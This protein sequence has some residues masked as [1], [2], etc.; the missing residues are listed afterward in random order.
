M[1]VFFLG[2]LICI[3][4]KQYAQTYYVGKNNDTVLCKVL[5]EQPT[6]IKIK[7]EL[8]GKTRK[9]VLYPSEISSYKN[10]SG[11]I[12]V[13]KKIMNRD[14]SDNGSEM[15]SVFRKLYFDQSIFL[16]AG[17]QDRVFDYRD[18]HVHITT[19]G[20]VTFY[21]VITYGSPS[22]T[23]RA[24]IK[25]FFLEDSVTGLSALPFADILTT[26]ENRAEIT[27]VLKTYLADNSVIMA[28]LNGE[29]NFN[30]RANGIK[31]ILEEYF[32]KELTD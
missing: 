24:V 10:D 30:L 20:K 3:S 17:I 6:F 21:E 1:K 12:M 25:N 28:K 13:S 11:E 9:I 5:K 22:N 7:V 8:K 19:N 18:G 26:K 14:S 4:C 16:P 2:F 31:K 15:I 29:K 23:G 27:G 32:G